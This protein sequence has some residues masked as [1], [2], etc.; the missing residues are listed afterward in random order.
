MDD[1]VA[2]LFRLAA[3][4]G[5]FDCRGPNEWWRDHQRLPDRIGQCPD[6]TERSC[7]PVTVRNP[8]DLLLDDGAPRGG[9]QTLPQW[10]SRAGEQVGRPPRPL[11]PGDRRER[12]CVR[13]LRSLKPN[14]GRNI[15]ICRLI[16]LL[17]HL[18]ARFTTAREDQ[19]E[20]AL[21][22]ANLVRKC[23]LA[24]SKAFDVLAQIFHAPRFA[25]RKLKCNAKRLH[26]AS[27]SK[28]LLV[29]ISTHETSH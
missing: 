19:A 3:L 7:K 5:T 15:A 8:L 27:V 26:T 23:V 14:A 20:I 16:D 29:T 1:P 18:A 2:P 13:P 12:S 6:R 10:P 21:G 28:H 4:C 17:D 24:Y 11:R 22:D 25:H 9:R